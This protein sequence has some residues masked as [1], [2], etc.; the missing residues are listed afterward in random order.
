MNIANTERLKAAI[1]ANAESFDMESWGD[2]VTN[3]TC[4]TVACI[5]GFCDWLMAVDGAE[6]TAFNKEGNHYNY[7]TSYRV[8]GNAI[9]FLGL[10]LYDTGTWVNYDSD[11]LF[12]RRRWPSKYKP[13]AKD[14]VKDAERVCNRIDYFV[15]TGL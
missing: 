12:L 7:N 6:F 11:A 13:V 15:K 8:E 3:T 10:D 1:M 9:D 14:P 4:G 2:N 5:A